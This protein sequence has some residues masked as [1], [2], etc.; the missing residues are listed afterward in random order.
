LFENVLI[1]ISSEFFKK[2]IFKTAEILVK[3][4]HSKIKILFIIEEKTLDQANKLSD[5]Y[6]TYYNI[7]ETKK[8]VIGEHIKKA[9]EIIFEE[10][11]LFFKRRGIP[12]EK[13]I[14]E[15][16]FSNVIKG[17]INKD[18]YDLVLM[19]FEKECILNYK[20]F[21]D[22]DTPVWIESGNKNKSILAVCSNLA[23][24]KKVPEI[25]MKIS[26]I[27]GWDLKIIY[28]VD[29]EDSV[30]VDSSGKRSEKKPQNYLIAN[31]QEFVAQIQKKN[32][33]SELVKGSLEKQIIKSAEDFN[34]GIV[35][36]GREKKK[37]DVLGIPIR[38]IKRKITEKCNYSVLLVK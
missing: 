7:E 21:D 31:G 16:E 38:N 35:I 24:N 29:V 22:I 34:A 25:S 37:R 8:E 19:G 4:F 9:N 3:N 17:Q 6:R 20:L 15:G 5:S 1:P 26:E 2:E 23:P 36:L 32:I 14:A 12:I 11:E 10:A 18:K 13:D 33:K 30:Q 27:L 28:V